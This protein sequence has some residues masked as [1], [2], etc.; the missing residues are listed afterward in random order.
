[1]KHKAYFW[2]ALNVLAVLVA[3]VV[4]IGVPTPGMRILFVVLL[5][6]NSACLPGRIEEAKR[7]NA[8]NNLREPGTGERQVD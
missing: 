3:G 2:L 6:I 7:A 5:T 8:G 4:L 1:M